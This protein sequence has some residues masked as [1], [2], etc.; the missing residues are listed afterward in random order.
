[1]NLDKAK[2]VINNLKG[3]NVRVKVNLGRNKEE[4]FDGIIINLYPS[5]FTIKVG[6]TIKSF[7]YSDVM[8]KSVIIKKL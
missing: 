8:I 3:E 5:I 2:N 1:M 7:S 6:E 4:F